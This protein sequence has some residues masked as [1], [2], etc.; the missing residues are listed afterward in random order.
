MGKIQ[1]TNS[2]KT[3]V[4]WYGEC[5]D[6]ECQDLQLTS[7]ANQIS[8]VFQWDSN[9][10]LKVWKASLP[11]ILNKAFTRLECGKLY[12]LYV[13]PGSGSFTIPNFVV[14]TH[15]A[16]DLGRVT[17]SCQPT[18]TPVTTPT[19]VPCDCEPDDYTTGTAGS[20]SSFTM[21]GHV[22][23][24]FAQGTKV[25]FKPST[26]A[27][28][29]SAEMTL[30]Y[31]NGQTAGMIVFT[32]AKPNNSEFIVRHGLTCYTAT[33]TDSNKVGDDTWNLT[34]Q[35]SK[36]LSSKCGDDKPL[37]TPTPKPATYS[38]TVDKTSVNEG[39]SFVVTLTTQN[40]SS[41]ASIPFTITG[42]QPE[43]IAQSLTGSFALSG[44]T[45]KKTF[46]TIADKST[47]G[48]QTATI[49]LNNGKASVSV[50]INDTSKTEPTPTPAV[51]SECCTAN[52][53][54]YGTDG[55]QAIHQKK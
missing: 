47:E 1:Q 28:A 24:G 20:S 29:L 34:L 55:V 27:S 26:F 16:Q 41:G 54:Q 4:G 43:D 22:L 35:K 40:L 6:D 3:V 36:T 51:P 2:Y 11:V 39:D 12:Y 45:D 7:Y 52:T 8:A 30:K 33:A 21:A 53:T 13:K 14:S 19:P 10:V 31:P 5:G 50:T 9:G 37:A 25:S 32:N 38:L 15:E 17:A 46:T 23:G 42:V 18:P 49:S 48:N 44:N